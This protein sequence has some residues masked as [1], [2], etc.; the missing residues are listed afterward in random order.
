M[1]R[2]KAVPISTTSDGSTRICEHRYRQRKLL[3]NVY[4]DAII[5]EELTSSLPFKGLVKGFSVF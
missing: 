4:R 1:I 3:I 5:L 2:I